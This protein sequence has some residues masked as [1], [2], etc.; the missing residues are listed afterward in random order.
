MKPLYTPFSQLILSIVGIRIGSLLGFGIVHQSPH[1]TATPAPACLS[2]TQQLLRTAT[3]P[4][5]RR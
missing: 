3:N 1:S 5:P 2:D 4:A